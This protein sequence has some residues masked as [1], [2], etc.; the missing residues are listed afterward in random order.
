[1]A[2]LMAALCTGVTKTPLG[3][4]LVVTEMAGLPVL[5]TTLI[6]ALVA[7][8]VT[9]PF[10]F[11]ESQR[12]RDATA[13]GTDRPDDRG[14]GKASVTT[15]DLA[16]GDYRA[17]ARFRHALRVFTSFSEDAARAADI[18]PA[19]HQ[20]LLAVR[21]WGGDGEPTI[22][23]VAE[24]LV[25]RHHSAVEL[26]QRAEAAGFLRT[27]DDPRDGRRH[28]LR[29]TTLGQAKLRELSMLHQEELRR[30]RSELGSILQ[31]LT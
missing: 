14:T 30:F 8:V 21:G 24:L 15:H 10:T 25:L 5:P 12:P 4:T 22:S 11:I 9:S 6:A 20:L 27:V 17:L 29:L 31:E 3:S 13:G 28:R 18:P 23:D 1:M 16:D 26:V 7:L 19:Q 2:A